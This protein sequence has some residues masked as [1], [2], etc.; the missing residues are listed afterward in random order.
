MSVNQLGLQ[1]RYVGAMVLAG[2]G[3]SLGYKHGEW[4]FNFSGPSIHQDVVK[5]GGLSKLKNGR[6]YFGS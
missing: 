3:D 1:S 5:L 2:V 6:K 4:E